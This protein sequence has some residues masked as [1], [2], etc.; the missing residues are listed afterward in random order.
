M[1]RAVGS[2]T[3]DPNLGSLVLNLVANTTTVIPGKR[4]RSCRKTSWFSS[5]SVGRERERDKPSARTFSRPGMW[6]TWRVMPA[7]PHH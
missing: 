3:G 1:L 5:H 6:L 4:W 7:A 2:G